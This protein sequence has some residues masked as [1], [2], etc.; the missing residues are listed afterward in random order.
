MEKQAELYTIGHSTY[1]KQQFLSILHFFEI[2]VIADVRS[3][4]GSRRY[5]HF[6]KENMEL[7]LA[8]N[9]IGYAHIPQLGGHRRKT[10][11]AD[12]ALTEGW[13]NEAFR[14]YS[15]YTLTEEYE[16][17]LDKLIKIARE[18]TTCVMCAESVPWKCHRLIISNSLV[19]KGVRVQHIIDGNA[20][21]HEINKYGAPAVIRDSKPVYPKAEG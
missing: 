6:N 8:E 7:W 19:A 2:K 4:P 21:D 13:E 16:R 10:E 5:P 15:A 14:N 1:D 18:K 9:G 12:E 20:R 3:Y 11:G 17:G